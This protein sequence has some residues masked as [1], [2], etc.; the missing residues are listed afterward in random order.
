MEKKKGIILCIRVFQIYS[1]F[2]S[3]YWLAIY[4]PIAL[5]SALTEGGPSGALDDLLFLLLVISL[6]VGFPLLSFLIAKYFLSRKAHWLR[7]LEFLI[8]FFWLYVSI[9]TYINIS[10]EYEPY[11]T[12]PLTIYEVLFIV[13]L[14]CRMKLWSERRKQGHD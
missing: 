9:K 8:F 5:K 6:F 3:C 4:M 1:Y 13:A 10:Y 12:I 14:I 2:L 7:V 11:T